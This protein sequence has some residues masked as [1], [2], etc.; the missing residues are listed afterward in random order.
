MKFKKTIVRLIASVIM[1][2]SVCTSLPASAI[3]GISFP[4][5]GSHHR[6]VS[7]QT[8]TTT[9]TGAACASY[10]DNH[11]SFPA[12]QTK[13]AAVTADKDA[14]VIT[15]ET[16]S[17][18]SFGYYYGS[19]KEFDLDYSVSNASS[20]KFSVSGSNHISVDNK[21]HVTVS[22]FGG[23]DYNR[24]EF[25]TITLRAYYLSD[26]SKYVEKTVSFVIKGFLETTMTTMYVPDI[27]L[28]QPDESQLFVGNTF[29]MEYST[30]GSYYSEWNWSSSDSNIAAVD[31]YGKVTIKGADY[32]YCNHSSDS[33]TF[34]T[35]GA[36][37]VYQPSES[38]VYIGNT[39]PIEYTMGYPFDVELFWTTDDTNVASV[40]SSGNVTIN[41]AGVTEITAFVSINGVKQSASIL[42]NVPVRISLIQ[43]SADQLYLG[44]S[45]SIDYTALNQEV[46]NWSSSDEKIASVDSKGKVTVKG[47]G[48]AEITAHAIGYADESEDCLTIETYKNLELNK[49]YSGGIS[50]G[51][52]NW[53]CFTAPSGGTYIFESTGDSNTVGEL[54][55]DMSE[56]ESLAYNDDGGT[57][58]N[59]KITYSLSSGEK[60]FLKVNGYNSSEVKDYSV[61]VVSESE[62]DDVP[63]IIPE[64]LDMN[65]GDTNL[66][67]TINIPDGTQVKW[68]SDNT[69]VAAVNDGVVTAVGEGSATIYA[70]CGNNL[71]KCK[72]T[73]SNGKIVYGDVDGSG[74]LSISDAAK[75]MSYVSNVAKYPLSEQALLCADVYQRGDGI[76]NLDALSV[77][78][79]LSQVINSLPE[80]IL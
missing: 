41:G 27:Y 62:K 56:D 75:I 23:I 46:M 51:K 53:F 68:T 70:V 42:L 39:F 77:Q 66:L 37:E 11:S 2:V 55:R 57:I 63:K 29:E 73:V 8:F 71:L 26:K 25:A 13:K 69:K 74:D 12:V 50:K 49:A 54:F 72:V 48:R 64:S 5:F 16:P 58:S 59:F 44:N 6:T 36:L 33:V 24:T 4:S 47:L 21:G 31:S 76:S 80:S 20:Y 61:S 38:E 10:N 35:Y 34:T 14:P 15:M 32:F 7:N 18:V 19:D 45:F 22:K 9:L 52:S 67:I 1:I 40:D 78:K 17:D 65:P 43:P 30:S 28:S 60:V 3:E 79:R